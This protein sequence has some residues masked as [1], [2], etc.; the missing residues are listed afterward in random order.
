[1][2]EY[3]S[4]TGLPGK[5]RITLAISIAL[6]LHTL[7]MS[8]LPFTV[9]EADRHRQTVQVELVNP[10]SLPSPETTPSAATQ[11]REREARKT[12]TNKN[13]P[14]ANTQPDVVTVD[15]SRNQSRPDEPRPER[16]SENTSDQPAENPAPARPSRASP[17]SAAGNPDAAAETEP[18]PM[19]RITRSPQETDP[20]LASLAVQVARELDK[21]PV[22]SSRNVTE[23]VTMELEL[24]L[25]G[26]GALT[27]AKVT[28]S[29]GFSDIDQAVY[30]AALLASPYPE[31]P[32]EYSGRKRFRVELIFTPERL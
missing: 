11:P 10:G 19:T 6:L 17:A 23:P 28:R 25:M 15:S 12:E 18:E 32:K 27:S 20:Y 30:Q 29:T 9:P 31:P 7:V 3:G 14:D 24:R 8:L 22:P 5:Y 26:S 4:V 1:M 16:P 13:G 2:L 21:R